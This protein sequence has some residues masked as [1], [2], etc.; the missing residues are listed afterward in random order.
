MS[1]SSSPAERP[2]KRSRCGSSSEEDFALLFA[3][4]PVSRSCAEPEFDPVACWNES[5]WDIEQRFAARPD[6]AAEL[7]AWRDAA[8][9]IARRSRDLLWDL[10]TRP[11]LPPGRRDR[12]AELLELFF[13]DDRDRLDAEAIQ[14]IRDKL[15]ERDAALAEDANKKQPPPSL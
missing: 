7:D 14:R 12:L 9:T 3:P 13:R 11:L 15:T 1:S 5:F 4:G 10:R 8:W 2:L 6:P